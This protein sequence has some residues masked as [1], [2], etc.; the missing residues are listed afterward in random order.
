MKKYSLTVEINLLTD[1]NTIIF[2]FHFASHPLRR[3]SIFNS[4]AQIEL[5]FAKHFTM[6]I[7][8]MHTDSRALPRQL[9]GCRAKRTANLAPIC[10][11]IC[12]F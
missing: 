2:Y 11:K 12:F 3:T 4:V 5:T 7:E 8:A 9:R 10:K 6:A 1:E